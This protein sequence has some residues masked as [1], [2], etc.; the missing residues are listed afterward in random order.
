M[1]ESVYCHCVLASNVYSISLIYQLIVHG[2]IL[3]VTYNNMIILSAVGSRHTES[4]SLSLSLL[5][6]AAVCSVAVAGP[7]F[8]SS[9]LLNL[10]KAPA[11]I[12]N[13]YHV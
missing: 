8:V 9:T 3:T 10:S 11:S 7:L 12:I 5:L 4:L 6:V 1:E 13:N 2:Y